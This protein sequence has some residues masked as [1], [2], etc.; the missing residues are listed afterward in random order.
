MDEAAKCLKMEAEKY[1]ID[2]NMEKIRNR[3]G[4][5]TER[6]EDAL[7]ENKAIKAE[8]VAPLDDAYRR[9]VLENWPLDDHDEGS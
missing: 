6:Y 9:E 2:V 4:I 3:I 5:T 1:L 8:V 7:E